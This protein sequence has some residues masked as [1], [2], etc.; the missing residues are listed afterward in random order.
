MSAAAQIQ[1]NVEFG[2][3]IAWGSGGLDRRGECGL[4]IGHAA[5]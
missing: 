2:D 1:Q 5:R 3:R 4:L